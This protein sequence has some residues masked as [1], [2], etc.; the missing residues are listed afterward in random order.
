MDHTF[1][2][3][4]EEKGLAQMWSLRAKLGGRFRRL[5]V[6]IRVRAFRCILVLSAL[7]SSSVLAFLL[8]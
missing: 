4:E 1:K 5:K 3:E 8:N 7:L 6:P 2:G